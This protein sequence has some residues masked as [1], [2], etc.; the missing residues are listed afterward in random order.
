MKKINQFAVVSLLTM[1]GLTA[2]LP[3][4]ETVWHEYCQEVKQTPTYKQALEANK[5][6]YDQATMRFGYSVIGDAGEEG[7]PI[8]I[9]LHGGGATP[10][11]ESQWEHMKVYYRQSVGNGIYIAPR[12]VRDTWNTHFNPESYALYD[13]LI[14]FM[15]VAYKVDPNRV[16][17]LGFSAGG[18]G[19]YN[20]GPCMAD[21]WAAV[22]MSAGHPNGISPKNLKHVP[23]L[24]QVGEHDRA[25]NRHQEAPK[26]FAQM[27]ALRKAEGG[28]KS[29][30]FVHKSRGH[31]FAD[32]DPS[33]QKQRVYA[34]PLGW[35][36]QTDK[37]V[38]MENTN[39]IHWL[40]QHRRN[41][42]P[43]TLKWDL[44]TRGA[45][46]DGVAAN[47]TCL[48]LSGQRPALF[49]WL[50]IGKHDAKSLGID[51]IEVEL[52]ASEN[53]IAVKKAKTYL[54]LLLN[55]KMVDFTK[56]LKIKI[57]NQVLST[58]LTADE[59]VMRR[60]VRERGD[61][62]FIFLDEV[63]LEEQNGTWTLKQ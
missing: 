20:L 58:K 15:S 61:R 35:L 19:V 11:N 21:R 36:N 17:V 1:V 49:Y 8:Y 43:T 44:N 7:Y 45:R 9:A 16:Y 47:G 52:I 12:G 57:G 26:Y 4:A 29:T 10:A 50:D 6:T 39:S 38:T 48:F 60:T 2:E 40:N 59:D 46:R 30:C 5:I 56:P 25:Y 31:N 41:P 34:N 23:L 51:E 33:G 53:T 27:E 18:D 37:S 55:E 42:Y 22:A 14:E 3:T 62:A 24:L 54:K 32:N 63:V 13:C 28:Y